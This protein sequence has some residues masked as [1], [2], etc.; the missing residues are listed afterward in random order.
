MYIFFTQPLHEKMKCPLCY[1]ASIDMIPNW[2][3]DLATG[4]VHLPS[5]TRF[6]LGHLLHYS[7]LPEFLWAGHALPLN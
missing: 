1:S 4:P 6:T 5:P 7:G 2:Q 3:P